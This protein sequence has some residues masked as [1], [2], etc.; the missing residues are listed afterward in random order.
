MKSIFLNY[1]LNQG[2][3]ILSFMIISL[4][5]LFSLV[6]QQMH[7]NQCTSC[8]TQ[9]LKKAGLPLLYTCYLLWE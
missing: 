2:G 4:S 7:V 6:F 5:F 9:G 3:M 1:K 8:F